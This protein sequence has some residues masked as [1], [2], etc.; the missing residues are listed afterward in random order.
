MLVVVKKPR[1]E[2]P[3][4]E[5]KGDVPD[6]VLAFLKREFTVDVDD[7]DEYVDIAETDWYK[8]AR[9]SRKP[10]DAV[11]V[12]R[13]NFGYS[14]AEL[15]KMLGGLSRHRVSDMEN[16]RRGISKEIAKKLATIFKVPVA[17]FI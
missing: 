11:R 12:Y 16:N 6:N 13:D 17:L 4:F 8:E 2:K 9:A 5:V 7:S 10:G 1:T 14:Q 15:G 3:I